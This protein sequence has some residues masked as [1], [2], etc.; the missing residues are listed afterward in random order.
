MSNFPDL[1]ELSIVREPGVTSCS[2]RVRG[3]Q[4]GFGVPWCAAPRVIRTLQP[5]HLA[6][7]RLILMT[8]PS[9]AGKSSL[10]AQ[11][12]AQRPDVINAARMPIRGAG[13]RA[14]IDCVAPRASLAQAMSI[15]TA[16]GLS[17]P[18][19]WMRPP[20]SLSAGECARL[21]LA[22]AVGTALSHPQ[23][24]PILCDEFA[25]GLH[26]RLARTI[27]FNL[28]RLT[29]RLGLT[30]VLAASQEDFAGDLRPDQHFRLGG[31]GY[32]RRDPPSDRAGEP[33]MSLRSTLKIEAGRLADYEPFAAMHYRR[34][35]LLGF[36]DRVFVMRDGSDALGVAVYAHPPIELSLRN[37]ATGGRFVRNGPR[38]NRE[39][40]ILRRLVLHPDVRG[41]GLG[42]WLVRETL[43]R[44]GVRF[45]ECLAAMGAI[46]PVF[47]RAGMTRVGVSPLPRGRLKLLAR[48]KQ[49]KLDPFASD[50]GRRVADQPRVAGLVRRTV[51]D[52]C[53]ATRGSP[54]NLSARSPESLAATFRQI[55]GDPPVYYLWDRAGEF[56][57][58][59]DP[60]ASAL[61]GMRE[62]AAPRRA[63]HACEP[64]VDHASPGERPWGGRPTDRHHPERTPELD[65]D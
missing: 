1:L 29:T 12:Q 11:L 60:A 24:P 42:H 61:N 48:M 55:I 46:N 43:P 10:L 65:R 59:H 57:R 32:A 33:A 7:G 2:R 21:R 15:L 45:V 30:M 6:R 9:G 58:R 62:E 64:G 22:V 31:D 18:D 63:D 34:R 52:W 40:R 3:V 47:E 20:A 14:V 56:P 25:A 39:V 53:Y 16:C 41:A 50:F 28:R 36:V 5:I 35:D 37:A 17:E 51:A 38:L 49:M 8:G 13:Q 23:R 27:A 54:R 19:L 4:W 26:R 44:V